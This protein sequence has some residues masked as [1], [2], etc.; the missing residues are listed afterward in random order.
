MGIF[1]PL[2]MFIVVGITNGLKKL[3]KKIILSESYQAR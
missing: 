3:Y 1:I 2:I